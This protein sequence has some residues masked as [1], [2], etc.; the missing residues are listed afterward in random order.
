MR[1][2]LSTSVIQRGKTGVGQ[3][4]LALL[5]AFKAL[6]PGNEFVLFVLEEDMPLFDFLK[7]SMQVVP[8]SEKYRPPVKNILWHQLQLPGLARQHKLDVLHVPSYRRLLGRRPCPLVA[9]IHDLAP[10]HLPDKYDW[11]RMVYGRVIVR[12][13]A[14]RQDQIIAISENT[15][16]DIR[17]FFQIKPE[18]ITVVQNGLDHDRFSPG[19]PEKAKADAAARYGL[20]KPFFLY[21]ARLEHPA[22]NHVPLI[23]AFEQFKM[24]TRSDWQLVFGGSDWHGAEAIHAAIKNSSVAAD[25]RSLG[26]VPD[27]S[28]PDLYRAADVFVYPSLYEG[29][30]LPPI[31]AMACGCPVIS[32]TR[33]SLGEVV[34]DAAAIVEPTD[35]H[36]I[37]AQLKSLAT[38]ESIRN[39]FRDAGFIR[40]KNFDWNRTAAETLKVYQKAAASS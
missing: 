29:F 11:K 12:R 32:S 2:G 27:E 13:L 4:V 36:S 20:N 7:G 25:I 39:R 30:G 8:V 28:L 16:R 1:I 17:R 26:F 21:V 35:I 34:G 22:K 38:D 5:R 18:R 10:F 31:E 9:T 15:A 23:A 40:A 14:H 19:P 33:G 37:A 3:Y 24:G 6:P